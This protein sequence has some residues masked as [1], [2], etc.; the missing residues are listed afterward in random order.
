ME[1]YSYPLQCNRLAGEEP[2]EVKKYTHMKY[3]QL[4][5]FSNGVHIEEQIKKYSKEI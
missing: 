5:I 4:Q 2:D 1:H 3:M